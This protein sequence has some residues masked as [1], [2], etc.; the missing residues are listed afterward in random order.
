M[1][2]KASW[3]GINESLWGEHRPVP[4]NTTEHIGFCLSQSVVSTL[5]PAD[6][7]GLPPTMDPDYK[8]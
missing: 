4:K 6:D 1:E 5:A 3:L 8:F 2:P 7:V